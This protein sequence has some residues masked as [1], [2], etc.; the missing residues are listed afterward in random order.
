MRSPLLATTASG[1]AGGDIAG[2]VLALDR[3]D[4]VVVTIAPTA[5]GSGPSL[6][7]APNLDPHRFELAELRRFGANSVRVTWRRDRAAAAPPGE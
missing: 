7:D 5:L 3:I 2:Q 6:V 1:C 4:E